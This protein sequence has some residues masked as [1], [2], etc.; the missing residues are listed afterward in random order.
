MRK[1]YIINKLQLNF[2]FA[3]DLIRWCLTDGCKIEV[4]AFKLESF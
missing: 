3:V 4:N 2:N 1:G